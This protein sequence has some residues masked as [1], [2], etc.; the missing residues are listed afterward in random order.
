MGQ[1]IEIIAIYGWAMPRSVSYRMIVSVFQYRF[2]DIPVS[3]RVDDK[4]NIGNI[5]IIL[6]TYSVDCCTFVVHC[7]RN[8]NGKI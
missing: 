8:W 2:F 7:N 6:H 3:H 1:Y 5:S 4:G